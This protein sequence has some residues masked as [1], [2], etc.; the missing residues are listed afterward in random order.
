MLEILSLHLAFCDQIIS[1]GFHGRHGRAYLVS[2]PSSVATP[3][4]PR[5]PTLNKVTTAWSCS[6]Y[7]T[8][9]VNVK[10]GKSERRELVTGQHIVADISCV[11][12]GSL[13][14]WKYVDAREPEQKYK[15]GKFILEK[16]RVVGFHGWEDTDVPEV[17]EGHPHDHPE[18]GDDVVVFDSDDED[19]CD[20]IFAGVWDPDVVAERRRSRTA[21]MSR[22]GAVA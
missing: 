3:S 21:S 9:L 7:P 4:Y 12:C 16:R 6:T 15:V 20:D 18:D 13:V 10:V 8:D 14:G 22:Y 17:D 5:S 11:T 2:P 1:K 19:E